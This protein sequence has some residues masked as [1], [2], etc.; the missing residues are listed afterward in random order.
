M[1]Y[2]FD[3]VKKTTDWMIVED[4]FCWFDVVIVVGGTDITCLE[5]YRCYLWVDDG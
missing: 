3:S 1:G 4:L 5:K 2:F